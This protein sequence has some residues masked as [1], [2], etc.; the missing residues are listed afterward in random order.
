M[1]G[2]QKNHGQSKWKENIIWC[3]KRHAYVHEEILKVSKFSQS[4]LYFWNSFLFLSGNC[5]MGYY[6]YERG[7]GKQISSWCSEWRSWFECREC[8][9]RGLIS[10]YT[11][12]PFS[13]F[14]CSFNASVS[15]WQSPGWWMLL[16]RVPQHMF[17]PCKKKNPACNWPQ[18][19]DPSPAVYFDFCPFC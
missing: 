17:L 3:Q 4:P 1:R 12:L 19:S 14:R 9:S 5:P 10:H 2:F 11:L 15:P 6:G 7:P 13:L 8:D 18:Q 16:T